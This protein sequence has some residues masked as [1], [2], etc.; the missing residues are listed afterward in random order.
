MNTIKNLSPEIKA[1][2]VLFVT[3]FCVVT[4][5]VVKVIQT[6]VNGASYGGF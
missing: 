4:Y 2:I 1:S 3:G 6:V 5:G